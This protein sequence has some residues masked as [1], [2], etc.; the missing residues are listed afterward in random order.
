MQRVTTNASPSVTHIPLDGP[1]PSPD[2]EGRAM[3][4]LAEELFPICRSIT[5]NGLRQTLA[6]LQRHIPLEVN[7]VPSGTAVLDWTVPREWNIREAYIARQ[8]GTRIV[9]FAANNL[10]IVQYS[11]P[12][13][14]IM[15]LAELRPHLHSLPDHPDWIPY[16][17]SYY[18]ENWGFC[19][20]H[21]QLLTLADGLYRVVVDADLMPG[22]LSYGELVIQGET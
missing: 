12:I 21:R 11:H 20:T 3:M 17:T 15:P 4:T 16:R 7:E 9:D 5:G 19:L 1:E 6:I 13:D 8:D 14:A 18:T 10:H 22:H 2:I